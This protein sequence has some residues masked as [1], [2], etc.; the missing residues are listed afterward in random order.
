MKNVKII[1]F[2]ILFTLI[3]LP[4]S[5]LA[6]W[7]NENSNTSLSVHSLVGS[8]YCAAQYSGLSPVLKIP[9]V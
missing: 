1:Y 6:G 5:K 3:T 8:P 9:L 2:V 7:S 4:G